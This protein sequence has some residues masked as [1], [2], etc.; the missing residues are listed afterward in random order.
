MSGWIAVAALALL[1]AAALWKLRMPL[2]PLTAGLGLGLAGYLLTSD[3]ATQ[4]KLAPPRAIDASA[5]PELEAARARLLQNAGDVGGWLVFSDALIR[6]GESEQA[7]EGLRLAVR[8][9]PESPDL[10]V[11]LGNALVRHAGGM[12]TPAARLAFGRASA[13]DPEHPGP[14]YFLG[15]AWLQA[16]E[17][18]EA[19]KV[20]QELAARSPPD[21]P[22]MPQLQRLMRGAR[23]MI[24]AGVDGGRFNVQAP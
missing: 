17:P 24:A 2:L 1:S 5:A 8:A 15:L 16:G 12:I 3:P 14:P 23:A 6:Q 11:G 22:Y 7:V 20:W 10:W 4:S 19:L 21:A 13:A 18:D 9:M